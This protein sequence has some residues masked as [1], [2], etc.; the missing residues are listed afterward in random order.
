M[1]YIASDGNS[2]SDTTLVQITVIEVD[3][4][5]VGY[6]DTLYVNEDEILVLDAAE[7]VLVNDLDVDCDI[8][9]AELAKYVDKGTLD[10]YS[11][12]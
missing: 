2:D 7:G 1:Y 6:A 8:L 10:F 9:T 11:D 5:P 3:D 4:P 12:G